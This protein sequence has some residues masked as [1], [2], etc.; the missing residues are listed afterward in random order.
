LVDG[1]YFDNQV[2]TLTLDR[3]EALAAGLGSLPAQRP[4]QPEVGKTLVSWKA[5]ISEI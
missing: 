1:P 5:V 3:G 2:A 4:G